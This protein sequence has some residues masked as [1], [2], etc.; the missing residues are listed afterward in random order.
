VK[1]A[2]A[3]VPGGRATQVIFPREA[4]GVYWI[5]INDAKGDQTSAYV[6]PQTAKVNAVSDPGNG[7]YGVVLR[8]HA[9]FNAAKVWGIDTRTI[10]GWLGIAWILNMILGFAVTRR[11]RRALRPKRVMRKGRGVY[12]FNLD[13]H[14]FF[15]LLLIIPAMAAVLTGLVY[16]FPAQADGVISAL[17]PGSVN[18]NDSSDVV[19]TSEPSADGARASLDTVVAGLGKRGFDRVNSITIPVGNPTGVFTAFVDGGGYSP[20]E[21]VF[22]SNGE[23]TTVYVDQYTGDVTSV[24]DAEPSIAEQIGDDW[25]NGIHFGTFGSWLSRLLWVVLGLG[26]IALAWTG[27]RMR[28]GRWPWSRRKSRLSDPSLGPPALV[29]DE[30]DPILE[31]VSSASTDRKDPR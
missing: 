31:P 12:A 25:T 15:G 14:N 6:N 13:W 21:G 26:T 16:E 11:R 30:Q 1:A 27:I 9:N 10:V 5:F 3:A 22:A 2:Q 23:T 18:S 20:E 8:L 24:D 4:N 7:V 19:P 29:D 17:A 28:A